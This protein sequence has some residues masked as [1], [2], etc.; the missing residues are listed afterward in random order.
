MSIGEIVNKSCFLLLL[1]AISVGISATD[2]AAPG[3]YPKS[4]MV[5]SLRSKFSDIDW[6]SLLS[7]ENLSAAEKASFMASLPL[8]IIGGPFAPSKIDKAF[9][10]SF[11]LSAFLHIV[12]AIKN[13]D[14]RTLSNFVKFFPSF[15]AILLLEKD[16]LGFDWGRK[17]DFGSFDTNVPVYKKLISLGIL[18]SYV[19]RYFAELTA[20]VI[21]RSPW[22]QS[23][24]KKTLNKLG[25]KVDESEK[26]GQS[27]VAM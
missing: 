24:I 19:G 10:L 12:N 27:R 6:D 15:F 13:E 23:V 2:N 25:Y 4:G 21:D 26:E 11:W 7:T 1:S 17:Y 20:M 3:L 18:G 9:G 5:A 22:A 8:Y 14:T 16:M